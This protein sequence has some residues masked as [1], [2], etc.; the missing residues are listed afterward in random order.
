[1]LRKSS[2]TNSVTKAIT[3]RSGLSALNSSH[4]SGLLVGIRLIDRQVG[5]ERG[6][7]QRIGLRARLLRRDIDGDD[8]LAALEQRFQHRLAERLLAV[9]DDT[10]C[11]P[12]QSHSAVMPA[13][14]GIQ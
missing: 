11:N 9:D 8:I 12:S 4:T 10:H 14:A 13:K 5:R 1:M 7:L 3:C 2:G 6:F